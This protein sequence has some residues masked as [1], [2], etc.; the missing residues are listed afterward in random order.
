[1]SMFLIPAL[2]TAASQQL[3]I[4]L[5]AVAALVALVPLLWRAVMGL[6]LAHPQMVTDKAALA[7]ITVLLI[8]ATALPLW[9]VQHVSPVPW[10]MVAYGRYLPTWGVQLAP[11]IVEEKDVPSGSG[12]PEVFCTY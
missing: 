12:N 4:G 1:F 3:L 7:G 8:V 2:G 11:G 5:S 6:V 10:G 9:L